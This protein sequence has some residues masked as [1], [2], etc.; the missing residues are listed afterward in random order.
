[1]NSVHQRAEFVRDATANERVASA[2]HAEMTR[3]DRAVSVDILLALIRFELFT[4]CQVY[5]IAA[6]KVHSQ[7]TLPDPAPQ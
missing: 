3:R 5:S 7:A 2:N 1:M 4:E 6:Q